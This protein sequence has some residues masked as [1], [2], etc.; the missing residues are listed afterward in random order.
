[1]EE[2][3]KEQRR[4]RGGEYYTD[5]EARSRVGKSGRKR[6]GREEVEVKKGNKNNCIKSRMRRRRTR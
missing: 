4:S 2:E 6:E 5:R 1:M 3:E